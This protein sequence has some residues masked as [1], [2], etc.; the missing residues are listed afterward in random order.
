MVRIASFAVGAIALS[1]CGRAER[2]SSGEPAAG[3]SGGASGS[4]QGG[5]PSGG[6]SGGPSGGAGG[7]L[8]EVAAALDGLVLRQ[9]CLSTTSPRA[10]RTHAPG[11]CP[12]DPDPKLHGA[13]PTDET[14]TMGGA[15]GTL[16][17]VTLRVQ[18]L[19][20]PKTYSG[21][22]DASDLATDGFAIGG[23]PDN[24]KNQYSVYSLHVSSPEQTYFLNSQGRDRLR[25]STLALDYEA[26]L[27]VEGQAT[28]R[29]VVADPN[30][31]AVRN[32]QEPDVPA[33]CV[34]GAFPSLE[35]AIAAR[36]G[37]APEAYDGQFLGLVVQAVTPRP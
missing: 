36:L 18:G 4:A 22:S 28:V 15:P 13:R 31:Q 27:T 29:A 5:G 19:V 34:P 8:L 37:V 17:D 30:C 11:L 23:V 12:S 35:P 6:S 32:C 3:G 9:P 21:A 2:S 14:L 33:D 10:C 25:H 16:Y 20:E 7:S 1:A 24:D 26:T